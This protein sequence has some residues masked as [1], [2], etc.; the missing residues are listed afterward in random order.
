[1]EVAI[2]PCQFNLKIVDA[3]ACL[4]DFVV[5]NQATQATTQDPKTF[6]SL[7]A[8]MSH[9]IMDFVHSIPYLP[10]YFILTFNLGNFIQRT[11]SKDLRK[12]D[13]NLSS[14]NLLV[15]KVVQGNLTN[16]YLWH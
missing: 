13:S 9:L 16:E 8:V 3:I 4:V 5:I 2:N 1:M 12:V 11:K 10:T 15:T 6:V 14:I 7:I